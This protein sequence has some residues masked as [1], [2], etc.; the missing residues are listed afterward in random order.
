[1]D[2]VKDAEA[3]ELF[4][5]DFGG[6]LAANRL[7]LAAVSGH[8]VL[9]VPHADGSTLTVESHMRSGAEV[10]ARLGGGVA[11]R[12]YEIVFKLLLLAADVLDKPVPLKRTIRIRVAHL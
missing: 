7:G 3:I 10:S 11:G 4:S 2:R 6:Q 8:Q 12:V 5:V 9:A 1:M